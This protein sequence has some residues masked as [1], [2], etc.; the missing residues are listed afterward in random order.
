MVLFITTTVRTT[1]PTTFTCFL[2]IQTANVGSTAVRGADLKRVLVQSVT[3]TEQL[4]MTSSRREFCHTK[5]KICAVPSQKESG[6]YMSTY[7][8]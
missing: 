2:K 1:N 7:G 3:E 8:I 6:Y 5:E 4:A